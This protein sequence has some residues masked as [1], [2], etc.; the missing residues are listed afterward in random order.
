[1]AKDMA[2]T[3]QGRVWGEEEDNEGMPLCSPPIWIHSLLSSSKAA[4]QPVQN[5]TESIQRGYVG[6]YRGA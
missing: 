2:A 1:M 3:I 6:V 5:S 4:V